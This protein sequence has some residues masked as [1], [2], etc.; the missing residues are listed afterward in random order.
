MRT[1]RCRGVEFC[2]ECGKPADD[3]GTLLLIAAYHSL[4]SLTG[5]NT[6][7]IAAAEARRVARTVAAEINAYLER[8]GGR[9]V[10]A[11]Q[12]HG[13]GHSDG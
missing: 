6:D 2:A 5:G 9:N 10:L 12:G 3:N 13:G 8:T 4:E 1:N 11:R 7:P